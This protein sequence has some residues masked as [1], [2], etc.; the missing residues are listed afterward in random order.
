M[1]DSVQ[2][3][4]CGLVGAMASL[5]Y[6]GSLWWTVR[7]LPTVGNPLLAYVLSLLLRMMV[8]LTGF[9]FL[10]QLGFASFAMAFAC[11]I[12]VRMLITWISFHPCR[13]AIPVGSASTDWK[14]S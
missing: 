2:L 8:L 1:S 13:P 7:R 4:A 5:A 9:Y 6:F 10:M 11:F 12:L 3:V 14:P